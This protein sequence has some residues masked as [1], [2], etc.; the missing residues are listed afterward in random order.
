MSTWRAYKIGRQ[1]KNHTTKFETIERVGKS[2]YYELGNVIL[3]SRNPTH[4]LFD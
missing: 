3:G 1:A 2:A 4:K